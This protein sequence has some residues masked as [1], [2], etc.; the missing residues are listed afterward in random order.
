MRQP[1]RDTLVVVFSD[2]TTGPVELRRSNGDFDCT[3]KGLARTLRAPTTNCGYDEGKENTATRAYNV[4]YGVTNVFLA[5]GGVQTL[6]RTFARSA[7]GSL[8]MHVERGTRGLMF[9][10]PVDYDYS[11]YVSWQQATDD[12]TASTEPEAAPQ[13][14]VPALC[15][16]STNRCQ[17]D[18]D[19]TG[20]QCVVP[21]GSPLGLCGTAP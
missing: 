17:T 14:R 2:A 12:G 5:T 11:T 8:V 15:G 16:T 10:L 3:A 20:T 9:G 4:F 19:C 7:D 13:L 18:A 21:P 6:R 1:D